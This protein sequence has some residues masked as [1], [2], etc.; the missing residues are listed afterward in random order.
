M[1]INLISIKVNEHLSWR[2]FVYNTSVD[3]ANVMMGPYHILDCT[4]AQAG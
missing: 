3:A 4:I 2:F 1:T